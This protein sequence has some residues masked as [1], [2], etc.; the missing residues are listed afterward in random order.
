MAKV[1]WEQIR[2]QL[3]SD[4]K[5]L[6]GDLTVSGSVSVAGT[7]LYNG[8]E[9]QEFIQDVT[10]AGIFISGSGHYYT[11]N[12]IKIIGNTEIDITDPSDKF[13]VTNSGSNVLTVQRDGVVQLAPQD[14]VPTAVTGGFYYDVSD[15]FFLG[16]NS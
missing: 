11:E 4:G 7:L 3:P 14:S 15:C 13:E 12:D 5:V 9:L 8:Q 6:T 2:G 16:F 10:Q 1:F